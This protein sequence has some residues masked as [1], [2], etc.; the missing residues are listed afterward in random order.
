MTRRKHTWKVTLQR[1]DGEVVERQ[2]HAYW[3]PAQEGCNE[4]VGV[5][6]RAEAFMASRQ[7]HQFHPLAV[8]NVD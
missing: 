2:V 5:T 1:D 8:A 7:Q 6:A 3:N 4:A